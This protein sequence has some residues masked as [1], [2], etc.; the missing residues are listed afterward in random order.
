MHPCVP[1]PGDIVIYQQPVQSG[2]CLVSAFQRAS[3]LAC[4]RANEAIRHAEQCA[5]TKHVDVWYT[6]DGQ[7]YEP[8]ASYRLH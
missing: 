5:A 6:R 1:E 3:Q 8:V 2:T 4:F 7:S